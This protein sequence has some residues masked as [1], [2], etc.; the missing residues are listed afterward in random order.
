MKSQAPAE[1]IFASGHWKYHYRQYNQY[2]GP[3]PQELHFNSRDKTVVGHGMD[4]V[5]EYAL[6]GT[7]SEATGEIEMRQSYRVCLLL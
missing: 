7:F 3:F 5:G 2:H 4:N 1:N 6:N